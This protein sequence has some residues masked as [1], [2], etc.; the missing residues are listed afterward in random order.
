MLHEISS[1]LAIIKSGSEVLLYEHKGMPA[2]PAKLLEAYIK[3]MNQEVDLM[4]QTMKDLLRVIYFNEDMRQVSKSK[5]DL[6][7]LVRKIVERIK[8]AF[9]GTGV[10]IIVSAKEAA[11]VV[12]SASDIE[13]MVENILI[14]ALA[15]VPNRGAVKIKVEKLNRTTELRIEHGGESV[16]SQNPAATF[17]NFQKF[18]RTD[19]ELKRGSGLGLVIAKKIIDW[20]RGTLS[21]ESGDTH[22]TSL[23]VKLPSAD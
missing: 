17:V 11:L 5:I 16:F 9:A 21:I 10:E 23:V 13:E 15:Q 3:D 19:S 18:P 8:S 7:A 6:A 20:H 4:A 12:G 2:G 22:G 1:S 14:R